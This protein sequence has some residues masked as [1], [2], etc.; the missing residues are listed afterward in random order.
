MLLT[1]DTNSSLTVE[2][3]ATATTTEP[4]YAASYLD[5]Q[6]TGSGLPWD[7]RFGK[8]SVGALTGTTPVTVVGATPDGDVSRQITGVTIFNRDTVSHTI[9]VKKVNGS[10]VGFQVAKAVL[11]AGESLQY[12]GTKWTSLASD[13]SAKTSALGTTTANGTKV[14]STVSVSEVVN[15][16]LH[17]TTLTFTATPLALADAAAGGGIE[18][19]DFPLGLIGFLGAEGSIA[20]TTTSVL[21]STLNA[22]VTYNWGIG[23][24]TQ[25]NGVLATTEQNILQATNGTASATINVAG[26]ASKGKG[27]AVQ[28]DGTASAIKAYLN[29]GLATNTDID[30]DATTTITG[31]VT[32][33]WVAL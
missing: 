12:D 7:K 18:I 22:G 4:S 11:G 25:A 32:I 20:E 17:Q 8:D 10:A 24:T 9:T 29:M 31:S 13:G 6:P 16:P 30:A 28:L 26:A 33:T 3:N 2:T 14:G 1:T 21:A 19:Y 27:A 15:G 23:S 5:Q